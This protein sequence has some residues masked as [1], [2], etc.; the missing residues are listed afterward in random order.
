MKPVRLSYVRYSNVVRYR[1]V[2]AIGK[3]CFQTICV[4]GDY[5]KLNAFFAHA[6]SF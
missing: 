2:G 6:I 5:G 4:Y 3:Q 1:M